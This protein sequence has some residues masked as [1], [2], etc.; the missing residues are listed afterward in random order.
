MWGQARL[1][2]LRYDFLKKFFREWSTL[3][4]KVSNFLVY[5]YALNISKSSEFWAKI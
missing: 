4:Q 2:Q 5:E 1:L 3:K